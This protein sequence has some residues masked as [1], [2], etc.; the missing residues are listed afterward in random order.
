[1]AANEYPYMN[2][3]IYN[4][5]GILV[6]NKNIKAVTSGSETKINT[7]ALSSGSYI[8]NIITPYDNQTYRIIKK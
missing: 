3:Y 5:N 1:L 6:Y 2:I 4:L 7:S 8:V